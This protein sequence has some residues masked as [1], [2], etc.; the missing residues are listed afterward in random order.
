[1]FPTSF[2][3]SRNCADEF[4]VVST[5]AYLYGENCV[6]LDEFIIIR[7]Y[8]YAHNFTR[9]TRN[10]IF[11]K[12]YTYTSVEIEPSKAIYRASIVEMS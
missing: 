1:M 8:F 11:R 9:V 12:T 4:S 6:A 5:V 7:I 2:V 3:F 10:G